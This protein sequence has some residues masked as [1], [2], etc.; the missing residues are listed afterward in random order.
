MDI[1]KLLNDGLDDV[2]QCIQKLKEN[3]LSHVG[4][5]AGSVAGYA[6]VHMRRRHTVVSLCVYL[7]MY[8]CMFVTCISRRSLNQVLVN[9][10]LAQR[11]NISNQCPCSNF[12]NSL[13][14]VN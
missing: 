5:N 2:A 1:E 9:A 8:I 6:L 11:D 7:C 3:A 13:R 10:V 12:I 14:F 4:Q